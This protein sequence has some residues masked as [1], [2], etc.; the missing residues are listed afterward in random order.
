MIKSKNSYII[1]AL[2]ISILLLTAMCTCAFWFK[3]ED[4]S[5]NAEYLDII[6]DGYYIVN[7]NQLLR[8]TSATSYVSR[9]D[10]SVGLSFASGF[11]SQFPA[12]LSFNAIAGHKYYLFNDNNN[13]DFRLYLPG[14][15]GITERFNTIFSPSTDMSITQLFVVTPANVD[16]N[17]NIHFNIIDLTL[18]FGSGNEP[19]LQQCKDLFISGYYD[20]NIGSP[21]P[22]NGFG[23][24]S[25]GVIDTYNNLGLD[26]V[27]YSAFSSA[28]I[29]SELSG[30]FPETFIERH[31]DYEVLDVPFLKARGVLA[32]PF[33]SIV[34]AG[35][36]IKF[37]YI[38]PS[39]GGSGYYLWC[40][41][42]YNN[43]F[44]PVMRIDGDNTPVDSEG[45]ITFACPFDTQNLLFCESSSSSE[46]IMVTSAFWLGDL[47][48]QNAKMGDIKVLIDSASQDA[49]RERD[50][51]WQRYYG[52]YG[53]GY[54]TI[55]NSG[56][57]A[58]INADA[59]EF[60]EKYYTFP[61]FLG[62]LF[63]VPV[64]TLTALLDF[65]VF[66]F[67]LKNFVFSLLTLAIIF[68]LIKLI[69]VKTGDK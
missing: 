52:Q 22:L 49:I 7:F 6:N 31:V 67:N 3:A 4:Q 21:M 40:G 38:D 14:A 8:F 41:I 9:V 47:Q 19:N 13:G 65:N 43:S 61:Q 12:T 20:Y 46:F 54:Q 25:Q 58:G 33:N 57:N 10:N 42:Y 27:N 32:V 24:Y 2:L 1:T 5:A 11:N 39:M 37:K 28:Y 62:A 36:L 18:M 29:V 45:Y 26:I 68:A 69:L 64:Q 16:L 50:E 51:Y 63:D 48:V 44:V 35:S 59:Q 55:Y 30:S 34:N 23:Y 60:A 66:G 17:V 53:Q 15:G 56:Y